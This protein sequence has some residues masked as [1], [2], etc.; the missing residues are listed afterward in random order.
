MM[1]RPQYLGN[2]IGFTLIELMIVVAIV[3]I[4][5]TIAIPSYRESVARGHRAEAKATLLE[6]AHF[7]ERYF[8]ENNRYQQADGT[9][10]TIPVTAAPREGTASYNVTVATPTT[11]TYTLTATPIA[12]GPMDG[13]GCGSFTLDNAGQRTAAGVTDA[14]V[15]GKCWNR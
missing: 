2:Q 7:L 14:A 9:A 11:T 8:T 10:P 1:Q 15:M 3:A 5:A 13:D 12:G 6:D 4:L